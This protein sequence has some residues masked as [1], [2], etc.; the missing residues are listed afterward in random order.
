MPLGCVLTVNPN[1]ETGKGAAAGSPEITW[2]TT[3]ISEDAAKVSDESTLRLNAREAIQ[4][5]K[6]PNRGAE[7]MWGGPGFGACCAVCGKPV[8]RDELG[9]EL[10]FR[11]DDDVPDVGNTHVH[12]QC[13]EAWEIE[14]RNYEAAR[15]TVSSSDQARW[16]A[17]LACG[18]SEPNPDAAMSTRVLRAVSND[19][20][21]RAS[22]RDTTNKREPE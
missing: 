5:G 16:G 19:G 1:D 7:R 18:A 11:R 17:P 14:R 21:I 20:T 3:E 8:K 2:T 4:A 9:F 22:E 12:I 13:F 15:E 10:D 6:L